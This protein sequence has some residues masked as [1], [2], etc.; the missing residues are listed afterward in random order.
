[1]TLPLQLAVRYKFRP[2]IGNRDPPELSKQT[3]FRV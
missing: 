2:A 3:L 1:M